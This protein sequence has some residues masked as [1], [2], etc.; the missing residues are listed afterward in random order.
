MGF[1]MVGTSGLEPESQ[2]T[3]DFKSTAFTYFAMR[4]YLVGNVGLEPTSRKALDPKSSVFT[5][6]TNSPVFWWEQGDS[7]PRSKDYESSAFDHLSY[8]PN[9][10][11]NT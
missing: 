6:F 8:T 4:R 7:N 2:K 3:V 5:S 1:Y 11:N 9:K 10:L